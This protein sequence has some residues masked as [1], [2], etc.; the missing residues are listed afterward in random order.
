MA[1]SSG[2][3]ASLEK[4][5]TRSDEMNS[6]TEEWIDDL[7]AHVDDAQASAEFQE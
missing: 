3:S 5:D 2:S 7:A 4:A 1:T 6:T